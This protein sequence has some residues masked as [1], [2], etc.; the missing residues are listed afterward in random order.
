[1]GKIWW[2]YLNTEA[3]V[4]IF[5]KRWTLNDLNS[6]YDLW[7]VPKAYIHVYTKVSSIKYVRMEGGGGGVSAAAYALRTRGKGGGVK[8]LHT[9][10]FFEIF[11][12]GIYN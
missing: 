6:W 4:S 7:N 5:K 8:L 9:Y 1:M 2:S 12:K 3:T 10:A 11:I